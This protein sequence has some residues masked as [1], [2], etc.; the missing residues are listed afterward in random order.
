MRNLEL[1]VLLTLTTS[2][3]FGA[4][5]YST[6]NEGIEEILQDPS[7]HTRRLEV[8]SKKGTSACGLERFISKPQS[9]ERRAAYS[10]FRR[11]VV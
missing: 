5:A 7:L 10:R 6:D 2:I 1:Q 9:L 11:S 4:S 3:F 8:W